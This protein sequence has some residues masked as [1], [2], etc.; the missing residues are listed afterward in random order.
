MVNCGIK[1]N[2]QFKFVNN[3]RQILSSAKIQQNG[4]EK[5]KNVV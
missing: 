1:N 2:L 3:Y 4:D 5:L